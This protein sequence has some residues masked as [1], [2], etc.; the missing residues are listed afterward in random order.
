MV[1]R[2]PRSLWLPHDA[3]GLAGWKGWEAEQLDG[4]RHG[5]RDDRLDPLACRCDVFHV[6]DHDDRHDAAKR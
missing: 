3:F 4:W 6:V 1:L 2:R 5:R